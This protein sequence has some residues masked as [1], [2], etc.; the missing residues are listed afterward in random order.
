M[1]ACYSAP[2]HRASFDTLLNERLPELLASRGPLLGYHA[3]CDGA[4]C[5]IRGSAW[6]FSH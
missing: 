6:V 5:R 3:E 1:T 2:W 4:T